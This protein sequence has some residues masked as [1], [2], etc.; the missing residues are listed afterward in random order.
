MF[1]GI[2]MTHRADAFEIFVKDSPDRLVFMSPA[3]VKGSLAGTMAKVPM[4]KVLPRSH[5]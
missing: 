3:G 4:A 1:Q 5:S 2:E